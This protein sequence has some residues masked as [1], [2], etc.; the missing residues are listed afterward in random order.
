MTY[1]KKMHVDIVVSSSIRK[2]KYRFKVYISFETLLW[3][4]SFLLC[5]FTYFANVFNQEKLKLLS[6]ER[7]KLGISSMLKPAL[8]CC[9]N[10][11][12]HKIQLV[13]ILSHACIKNENESILTQLQFSIAF[14]A[15]IRNF[16]TLLYFTTYI[17]FE[18]S[19]ETVAPIPGSVVPILVM[20]LLK[21][22][23]RNL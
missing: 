10:K 21:D 14:K 1:L 16:L 6:Y 20:T 18:K 19:T 3:L 12:K 17:S 5:C 9:N 11:S 13:F 2:G 8:L 22:E 15:G 4:Y 23:N 7:L